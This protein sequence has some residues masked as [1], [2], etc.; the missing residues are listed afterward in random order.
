M[1]I[2]ISTAHVFRKIIIVWTVDNIYNK[3]TDLSEYMKS[4]K[5]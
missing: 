4:Y 1:N 5:S 2:K 3:Y